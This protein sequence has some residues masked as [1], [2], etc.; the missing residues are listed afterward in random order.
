[1]NIPNLTAK[2]LSKFSQEE[3]I[4]HILMLQANN[5]QKTKE[6]TKLRINN[7]KL[8]T[9]LRT[10][11][12]EQSTLRKE[13]KFQTDCAS[14]L[15]SNVNEFFVDLLKISEQYYGFVYIYDNLDLG[16]KVHKEIKKKFKQV[17]A[18]T[19]E[20]YASKMLAVKASLDIS[21]S[22]SNKGKR[23]AV[24]DEQSQDN[25]DI[26]TLWEMDFENAQKAKYE[27][28]QESLNKVE[29]PITDF[30][31]NC[32]LV[33]NKYNVLLE[34]TNIGKAIKTVFD[35][36]DCEQSLAKNIT[37]QDI[38]EFANTHIQPF[39]VS[40]S[41]VS[42]TAMEPEPV[43]ELDEE[44][45]K[46]I[47][48]TDLCLE[49]VEKKFTRVCPHCG[50]K[51]TA[52][53]GEIAYHNQVVG[54]IFNSKDKRCLVPSYIVKCS[55]CKYKQTLS[56]LELNIEKQ[57]HTACVS[58]IQENCVLFDKDASVMNKIRSVAVQNQNHEIL[59]SLAAYDRGIA[60]T[61][62]Y[63]E[64]IAHIN[65]LKSSG[66]RD[67]IYNYQRTLKNRRAN[68]IKR[69]PHTTTIIRAEANDQCGAAFMP[70]FKHSKISIAMH[71]NTLAAQHCY[72]SKSRHHQADTLFNQEELLSRSR[73]MEADI[74]FSRAYLAGVTNEIKNRLLSE[75]TSLHMDETPV[76]VVCLSNKD[77]TSGTG[78]IWGIA[79]SMT[80]K[81]SMVYME[82][83]P[84]RSSTNFLPLIEY[85]D[86]E[87][88]KARKIHSDGFVVYGS[89][90]KDLKGEP[91]TFAGC[92]SH[93][94]RPIH[95]SFSD[96]DLLKIYN[97]KLLPEGADITD[98][99]GNLEEVCNGSEYDLSLNQ[100]LLLIIYYLIN[101]LFSNDASVIDAWQD[102]SCQE[103]L[104]SLHKVRQEKSADLVAALNLLVELYSSINN[105]IKLSANKRTF[106]RNGPESRINK[107]CTY[108]MNLR[109]SLV[110]FINSPHFA[111]S[112]NMIER[113]FRLP[114]ISKHVSLSYKTLDGFKAFANH[115]TIIEN[116]SINN[117]SV[118]QYI[119]WLATKIQER[120]N[121]LPQ[122][123]VDAA[124]KR[125]KELFPFNTDIRIEKFRRP[126]KFK[127]IT[128]YT[129]D[130]KS[131]TKELD[132][133][134]PANPSTFLYDAISYEGLTPFDFSKSLNK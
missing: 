22:E 90:Q 16:A 50:Q 70:A 55:K 52:K 87:I 73:L 25:D 93:C 82:A 116:C 109:N 64:G 43:I 129:E 102:H 99:L 103:F 23:V 54:G 107:F 120:I 58:Y 20:M 51:V 17:I 38:F 9:E 132:I 119:P 65:K 86:S 104:D 68:D 85:N 7:Y 35:G 92:F 33:K 2:D 21:K 117:V 26:A 98:F 78:W 96:S 28:L 44:I 60:S 113:S 41:R 101:T 30:A 97:E 10:L 13:L 71:A 8:N 128:A 6:E 39:C 80:S 42:S 91:I 122:S 111:L 110:E 95:L 34:T 127:A 3:L 49:A 4:S 56:L 36:I 108:W 81:H 131:I 32:Q 126:T 57:L 37:T 118:K 84:S 115:M 11:K 29:Q 67:A 1:M 48:D 124:I 66:S 31:P 19:K 106:Q 112:N 133:Y 24:I 94:R 77:N 100:V 5:E 72:S 61:F 18:S 125:A 83:C 123:E 46:N 75:S 79:S 89:S 130:G 69:Q 134:D 114:A 62:N 63:E 12:E 47:R 74:E 15:L 59:D 40:R 76:K 27:A 45:V 105:N 121:S 14:N 88:F 53:I